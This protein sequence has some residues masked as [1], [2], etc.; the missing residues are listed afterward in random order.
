MGIA[1]RDSLTRS[2]R[3]ALALLPLLAGPLQAHHGF[4][5]FAMNEDIELTGVITRLD[6]VNPHSWVYFD[7]THA[8]GTRTPHRCELRSATTLRRSGWTPAMFPAGM[9]ITIQGSPDRNE[10]TACYTSTITFGDGS[11]LDRYGQR[12]EA[13][14]SVSRPARRP[15]GEPNLAGDWAQEQ[16]VMTDPQGRDGVL[17]ALSQSTQFGVGGVPEG[18]REIPG[19]R[20][21]AEA[22]AAGPANRPQTAVVPLTPAGQSALQALAAIPRAER[23]C[24]TGSI[25]SDWSGEPVNRIEQTAELLLLRY[26]FLGLERRVD[27]TLAAHPATL[28]AT[29]A[30]HSI[31]H[32]EGDVLVVDTVGFLPGTLRGV[33]PHS[34]QLHVVERFSLDSSTLQLRRDYTAEDPLY[35]SAPYTGS[36]TLK[37]SPVPF[38]PEPCQDL[39]PVV[40]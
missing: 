24:S 15:G 30:G 16:L 32:W 2:T 36:D 3:A 18:Q 10:K 14:V 39:T 29:R 17:V 34:E 11:R 23:A 37:L 38:S 20:G 4:G 21:T 12:I 33:T 22:E 40:Q 31:G 7:V 1:L 26:G 5:N 28:T 35:F 6:F 27:L 8:D 19:A 13:E 25:L 9:R